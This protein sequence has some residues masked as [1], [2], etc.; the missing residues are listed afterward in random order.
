MTFRM[1]QPGEL[2]EGPYP[3]LVLARE[4]NHIDAELEM[5]RTG[6]RGQQEMVRQN[7]ERIAAMEKDRAELQLYLDRLA[8][9]AP[10]EDI[11]KI[12]TPVIKRRLLQLKDEHERGGQRQ[13]E[14][15][16]ETQSCEYNECLSCSG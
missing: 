10:I 7:E 9:Q 6:L 11:E 13:D 12:Q 8:V 3:M 1:P 16:G 14:P 4:L 15:V 5:A 2:Y